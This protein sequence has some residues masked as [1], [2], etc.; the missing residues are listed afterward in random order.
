MSLQNQPQPEIP[1][2]TARVARA[3]FKKGNLFLKIRDSLGTLF[4]DEQFKDLFPVKGQPAEAPWRLALVLLFQFVENLPDR[5]AADAVRSRLDWKYALALELEDPGFDFS[6]LSQ[7]R[8]RLL[9]GKAEELLLDTLLEIFQ[10]QGWLKA[11]G[12]QRTDST[13]VLAAVR[14]LNRLEKV[15][16]TMVA[17]L[18]SLAVVAPD[19]L[20]S[21]SPP[22]WLERYGKRAENFR[23]PRTDKERETWAVQV[24][25]DGFYLMACIQESS[26]QAV[27]SQVPAV[28]TLQKVWTEQYEPDS[29]GP[30]RFKSSKELP[31]AAEQIAS[32]YDSEAR[33]AQKRETGWVGY[34]VHFTETCDADTPHLLVHVETTVA[35]VPDDNMLSTIHPKLAKKGLLPREH[36]VDMGY[37]DSG[38]LAESLKDFGIDVVGPM[39]KNPSWQARE[40]GFDKDQFV[41]DWE[42]ETVT[43]PAGKLSHRWYDY[44]E[45]KIKVDKTKTGNIHVQFSRSDCTP[46]EH[47]A[48]CTRAKNEARQLMLSSREEYEALRTARLRQASQ[49]FIRAYRL[50]AGAES[51]HSQA[52]RRCDVRH[53]RYLGEAKTHLQHVATAAAV[54]LVRVW[55]WLCGDPVGKTR[56]SRYARLAP[57]EG[58][59][60]AA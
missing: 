34:K 57:G 25:Y 54:N 48:L 59:V 47:R 41:V 9:D 16:Q 58:K 35:T 6:V 18:E 28:V 15:G 50:R 40:G 29:Q 39:A 43:C 26:L 21:I 56:V 24:G 19:W 44:R 37:T 13:H 23:L 14:V 42:K 7:F 33:F 45:G 31:S 52:I 32:P 60:C 4:T 11:G 27:L 49:A 17:T 5:Q 51:V 3:A 22:Q 46:C 2:Q 36:L 20:V 30:P 38:I 53:C 10:E 8:Q 55:H 1:E 12:K